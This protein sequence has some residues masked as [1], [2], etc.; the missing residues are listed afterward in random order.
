[1]SNVRWTVKNCSRVLSDWTGRGNIVSSGYPR[2]ELS[3]VSICSSYV[4]Y[5]SDLYKMSNLV[6][7]TEW[8]C[9]SWMWRCI[10][11][12]WI[13]LHLAS[14]MR[15]FA[16]WWS[17]V[18]HSTARKVLFLCRHAGPSDFNWKIETE[19]DSVTHTIH[20]EPKPTRLDVFRAI[21]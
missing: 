16:A 1:M 9:S 4:H 21:Y 6:S 10:W 20:S 5:F 17:C 3:Y 7:E 12:L 8:I 2:V 15:E 19:N 13:Y 11:T 14:L 18:Y